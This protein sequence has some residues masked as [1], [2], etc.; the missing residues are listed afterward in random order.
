VFSSTQTVQSR[1]LQI[2]F[3]NDYDDVFCPIIDIDIPEVEMKTVKPNEQGNNEMALDIPRLKVF[4]YNPTI[5]DW[6]PFIESFQ[7]VY[8]YMESAHPLGAK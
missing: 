6:E 4:Y 5:G 1:G 3:I 2:L 8:R 7:V